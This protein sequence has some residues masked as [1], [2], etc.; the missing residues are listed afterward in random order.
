MTEKT[1]KPGKLSVPAACRN[2]GVVVDDRSRV[3]CDACLLG[4]QEVQEVQV[5][6]FREAGRMK[7]AEARAAGRDPSKVGKAKV[8]RGRKNS[9]R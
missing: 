7:L 5:G 9:Q 4:Y 2:C 1:T 6:A 3:Y 8:K